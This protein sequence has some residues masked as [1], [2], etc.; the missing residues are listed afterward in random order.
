MLIKGGNSILVTLGLS[1]VV[2]LVSVA[3]GVVP[4]FSFGVGIFIFLIGD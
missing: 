3:A 4:A 2:D 1:E